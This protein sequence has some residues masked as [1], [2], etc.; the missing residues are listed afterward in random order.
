MNDVLAPN[1]DALVAGIPDGATVA[2]FKEGQ[3]VAAARALIR[4]GVRDLH[5]VTVPTGGLVADLLIG[6]GCVATI[7]TSGVSLG[8]FG[9]APCFVRAVKDGTV[10]PLDATCPAVY[11]GLQ[12]AEKG[13]P[14]MPIRG[15]I[16]SDVLTHRP[17]YRV[18]RNPFA[19]HD[20]PIVLVPAIRPDV[21]LLH[22][23]LADRF[24]NVRVGA[25]PEHRI[26]AHAARTT[27]VTCEALTDDDLTA[28]EESAA[29]ALSA[30]YVGGIAVAERG[31]WPLALPGGYGADAEAI[32]RYAA[33]AR[34]EEGL[35]AWLGELDAQGPAAA[36]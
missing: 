7:E 19:D 20:D 11:T 24:G 28:D 9:L 10:R 26:M 2:V 13:I 36:E 4:R 5:L 17:D 23:P 15:L 12:A 8:E 1:L 29:G 27:L 32:R 18:I 6:A 21:A 16:G 3:P 34:N 22:V 25:Q 31:A 14:F 30:L 33:L 35:A